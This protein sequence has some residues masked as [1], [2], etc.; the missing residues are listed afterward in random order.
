M[1]KVWWFILCAHIWRAASAEV[2]A[3]VAASQP[4]KTFNVT[5]RAARLKDLYRKGRAEDIGG[6]H[7]DGCA[8]L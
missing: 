1:M 7:A 4:H 5:A 8:A 6:M 3:V 2:P